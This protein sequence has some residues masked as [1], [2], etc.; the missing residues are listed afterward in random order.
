MTLLNTSF[1]MHTSVEKEFLDWVRNR[2]NAAL[3]RHGGMGEPTLARMLV[4]TA[5]D[6]VSYCFQMKAPDIAAA[7]AWHEGSVASELRAEL[8]RRFGERI[9]HF[10]TYMD[11][12]PLQ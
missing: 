9:V 10:T 4:E 11:I 7:E 1:H 2:Y 3:G 8:T 6:T 12:Q 5:P